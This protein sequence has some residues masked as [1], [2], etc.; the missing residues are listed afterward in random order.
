MLPRKLANF[1]F[2]EKYYFLGGANW[3]IVKTLATDVFSH[4]K[5]MESDS[6][7]DTSELCT[8]QDEECHSMERIRRPSDDNISLHFYNAETLSENY[9]YIL[10]A[11]CWK[12]WKEG[13]LSRLDVADSSCFGASCFFIN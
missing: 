8:G 3:E 1:Q 12:M 10:N 4:R 13:L 11:R 6:I 5:D 7:K 2:G 9:M